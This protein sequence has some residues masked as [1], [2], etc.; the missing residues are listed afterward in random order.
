MPVRLGRSAI[1]FALFAAGALGV[2]GAP[3][4][5]AP[6]P[7]PTPPPESP[8]LTLFKP[9]VF[10]GFDD[11]ASPL[12]D[13]LDYLT[14]VYGVTFEVNE[15]AFRDEQ[16]EDV[17]K[18]PVGG[19]PR[20]PAASLDRVLRKV[21]AKLPV[22]SGAVYMLRA[23]HIEITTRRMQ[24]D[25]V[26]GLYP[27]PYLPLVHADIDNRPL[28]EALRGLADQSGI[29]IVVDARAADRAKTAVSATFQ[30]L[31]LDTA[32]RT[33][34]DM[35][36]LKTTLNDNVLYVSTEER[37]VMAAAPGEALSVGGVM[38]TPAQVALTATVRATTFDKR[39][40]NEALQ[41]VLKTTGMKLVV[42][43]ARTGEKSK[44]PV[45]AT[46]DG[47]TVEAAIRLLAD[48]AD[49]R[50]VVYDN[51]VYLTTKEN[52]AAFLKAAPPD[53]GPQLNSGLGGGAGALG[54]LG[55]V[56]GFSGTSGI[57]GLGG[58]GG[59]GGGFGP[60]PR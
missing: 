27:G 50:P 43:T 10:S 6:A 57:G 56:T 37:T 1:L 55:G 20:L 22:Q 53:R 21:L 44:A 15:R 4:E 12:D 31:P 32:V 54:A 34:A 7:K 47:T 2:S 48:M 16:V 30:N 52:A 49:L 8:A 28:S 13:A 5:A 39:P 33:L 3:P 38:S 23:D 25:E 40:L 41:D 18:K 14:R 59:F 9:R 60:N 46:L 17:S 29:S 36:G 19:I 11:P 24:I 26:W 42:D 51:V 35:A 45:S 58:V